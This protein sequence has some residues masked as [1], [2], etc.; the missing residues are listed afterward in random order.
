MSTEGETL[1]VSVLI[2]R[3]SICPFCC[4]CLGCCAAEFGS[5]GGT[6]E[7]PSITARTTTTKTKHQQQQNSNKNNKTTS[8]TKTTTTTT[9]T[10]TSSTTYF[11]MALQPLVGQN[12][13]I[14]EASPTHSDMLHWLGLW[15]SDW[16]VTDIST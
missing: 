13:L 7:L 11:P 16:P 14:F 12:L 6:Y 10:T 4:V 5:S 3:C 1:Q 8:K 15:M 9:T 2:Y